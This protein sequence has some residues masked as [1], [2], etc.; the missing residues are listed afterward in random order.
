MKDCYLEITFREGKALAAYLYL[1]RSGS[2]RTAHTEPAR[3]VI[4]VDYDANDR[5]VGVEIT[6]PGAVTA[7]QVNEVLVEIGQPP[8]GAE[9]LAP[10]GAA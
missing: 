6:S 9:E 4:L 5:P 1:P 8:L 2:G 10:L 7:A 3:A